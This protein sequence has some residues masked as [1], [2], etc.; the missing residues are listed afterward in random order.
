MEFFR[1]T[2]LS[3]SCRWSAD[4]AEAIDRILGCQRRACS[5]A[6]STLPPA[7]RL[8]TEKRSTKAS[9]I[10]SVLLPMEP[11]EP[12]MAMRFMGAR[13]MVSHACRSQ[14]GKIRAETG[15]VENHPYG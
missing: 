12:R 7:A 13:L 11:V 5:N 8:V 9:T 6:R 1:P 10:C 4:S 2:F 3:L 15:W 14:L